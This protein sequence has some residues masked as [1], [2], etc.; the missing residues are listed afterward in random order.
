LLLGVFILL[1]YIV[2]AS[3]VYALHNGSWQAS[4]DG[5]AMYRKGQ[6]SRKVSWGKV[7]RV[8]AAPM[9]VGLYL[10]KE[11]EPVRLKWVPWYEARSF[12]RYCGEQIRQGSQ[13]MP[14]VDRGTL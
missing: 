1:F 13:S 5:I 4:S 12:A 14:P 9:A 8:K 7:A 11:V 3:I 2:P 6:A 10:G